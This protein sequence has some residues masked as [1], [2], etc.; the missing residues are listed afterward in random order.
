MQTATQLAWAALEADRAFNRAVRA[1]RRESLARRLLRRCAARGRLAVYEAGAPRG[2]G[3]R[4]GVRDIPLDAI[5]GTLEPARAAH[6]DREFRP[7]PPLRSRW[8]RVWA[9][10]Q[11]GAILPPIR[12]TAVGDAYAIR[13]GHNRVSVAR[14]RG[15]ATIAAIVA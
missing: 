12:V 6:F 3:V 11:S 14:A 13:D 15:A 1:R 2:A 4:H 9:A 8:V 7:A 5:V 10:Q